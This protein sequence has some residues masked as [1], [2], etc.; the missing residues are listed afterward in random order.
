MRRAMC[1]MQAPTDAPKKS[2]RERKAIA[3][4]EKEKGNECFKAGAKAN[5]ISEER[6]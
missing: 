5:V 4:R 3:M 6:R 2:E 1:D